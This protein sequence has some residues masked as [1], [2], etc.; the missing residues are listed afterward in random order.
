[1]ATLDLWVEIYGSEAGNLAL[2]NV[3]RGGIYIAGGIAVKVLP[4]LK[5]GRFAAAVKHKEK[6]ADFLAQIP[7]CV[8]L[9][10]ELP[11]IGAANVA[12]KSP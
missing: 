8:I 7:I 2:R 1:V 10:E 11:L 5:N 12:W 4:K 9:N 6:L 3:A